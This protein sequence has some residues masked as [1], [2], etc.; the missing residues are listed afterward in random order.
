MAIANTYPIVGGARGLGESG[1]IPTVYS[2]KVLAQLFYQLCL[3]EISSTEYEGEIKGYGDSVVIATDPDITITSDLPDMAT[4]NFETPYVA[5]QTLDINKSESWGFKL[6]LVQSRQSQIKNTV[7]RNMKTAV[8]RLKEQVESRVFTY[9]VGE[10]AAANSGAS[11]GAISAA[12]EL[13]TSGGT[14]VSISKTN[15]VEQ[16]ANM[17]QV[18]D[19]QNIDPVGRWV[20]IPAW[21]TNRLL[22][23]DAADAAKMGDSQSMQRA[24][25]GRLGSLCG[26]TLYE[27]N[28]LP[29]TTDSGSDACT[30]I[31]FGHK[32]GLT[33]AGQINYQDIADDPYAMGVKLVKGLFVYGRRVVRPEA[34]GVMV[35]K[36]A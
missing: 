27:S 19:E 17:K 12:I 32:M 3:T 9:M 33:F 30:Y 7:E 15:I 14:A 21:F 6:G 18:L 2:K 20:I 13:G 16:L 25:N 34:L 8:R 5:P 26:F 22:I 36:G 10:V 11:S 4:V 31:P 35:A 24:P 23:S 29:T 28:K 1:F